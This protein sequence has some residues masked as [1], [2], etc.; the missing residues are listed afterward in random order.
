MCK[1]KVNYCCSLNS[2]SRKINSHS[3]CQEDAYYPRPLVQDVIWDCLYILTEPVVTCWP[4]N[5]LLREKA[6][7]VAMKHIHYEDENSRYITI[8]CVEKVKKRITIRCSQSFILRVIITENLRFSDEA[9]HYACLR[10]GLKTL[11]EFISRSI[12]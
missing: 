1:G 8:G 11:T 2:F 4:F 3:Y 5:K 6:L 9:R 10:V 12:F 7:G